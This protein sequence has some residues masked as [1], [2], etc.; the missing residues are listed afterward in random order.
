MFPAVTVVTA[1]DDLEKEGFAF[2]R[3]VFFFFSFWC[4]CCSF[5][6]MAQEATESSFPPSP[7]PVF[8]L[9]FDPHVVDDSIF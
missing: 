9:I 5:T 6:L 8:I 4:L 2:S 7:Q 3:C 1:G